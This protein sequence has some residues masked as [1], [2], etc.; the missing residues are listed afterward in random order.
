MHF[1]NAN[2]NYQNMLKKRFLYQSVMFTT[3][4]QK[5]IIES[6]FS[7]KEITLYFLCRYFCIYI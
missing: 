6:Q 3:F 5:S 1:Q 4:N 7:Q 2:I